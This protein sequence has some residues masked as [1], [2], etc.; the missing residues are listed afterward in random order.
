ME[1]N[2]YYIPYYIYR[3]AGERWRGLLIGCGGANQPPP[4]RQPIGGGGADGWQWVGVA[5]RIFFL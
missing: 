5:V 4:N 1:K 2:R 3:M